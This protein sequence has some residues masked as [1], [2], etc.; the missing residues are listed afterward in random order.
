[1]SSVRLRS[2]S[3][4]REEEMVPYLPT[5][6]IQFK[7]RHRIVVNSVPVAQE[8]LNNHD[9]FILVTSKEVSIYLP[10]FSNVIERNK[11]SD[12]AKVICDSSDL[13]TSAPAPLDACSKNSAFW[14]TFG[15]KKEIISEAPENPDQSD[16][17]FETN[18]VSGNRCWK[19]E[20]SGSYMLVPFKDAWAVAPSQKILE[21]AEIFIFEFD[22]EIY[23]WIG[24][25]ATFP[26]RRAAQKLN[27]QLW[28]KYPRKNGAFLG[29]VTQNRETA[30]FSEKFSDWLRVGQENILHPISHSKAK[31]KKFKP[32][33]N[34]ALPDLYEKISDFPVVVGQFNVSAGDG[35]ISDSDGRILEISTISYTI[36]TVVDGRLSPTNKSE[37]TDKDVVL[38]KWEFCI[39]GTGRWEG[40]TVRVNKNSKTLGT[41]VK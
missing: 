24:S 30:L 23:L 29:K 7:G 28:E 11:A 16:S 31:S 1:M 38:V 3:R 26:A 18:F 13:G 22:M 35:E 5:L 6:L 20:F 40:K 36:L 12:F 27:K 32:V 39:F 10:K 4:S 17:D 41:G 34:M 19:V 21:P 2:A 9:S 37:L 33:K 15:L 25:L 8:S 14:K